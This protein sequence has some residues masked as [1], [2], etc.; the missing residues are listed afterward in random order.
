MHANAASPSVDELAAKHAAASYKEF[1]ELLAL[2]NDAIVPADKL[3]ETLVKLV[4]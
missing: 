2:P 1:V 3:L 4:F